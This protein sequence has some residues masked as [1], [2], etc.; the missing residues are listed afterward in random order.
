MSFYLLIFSLCFLLT[1]SQQMDN[2][3]IPC[4]NYT[5]VSGQGQCIL[6]GTD[7]LC[8]C[9][10]Y[11]DSYP[12]NATLQCNYRKKKQYIA[13]LL[14]TLL[15]YGAGHLYCENYQIAIPKLIYWVFCYCLFIYLRLLIKSKEDNNTTALIIS[16]LAC[17]FLTIMLA[18]Q[19]A[20]VI[21]Y[22]LNS[23]NDGYDIQLYPW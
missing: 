20:D 1:R 8:A 19:L 6:N 21:M 22:G 18:W 17:L 23:Y 15:T 9:S 12:Q 11:F 7:Y 4:G 10:E 5:C 16:L 13:F 3:T 2:K 14:E